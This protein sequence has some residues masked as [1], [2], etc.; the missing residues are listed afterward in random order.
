MQKSHHVIHES[1]G[2]YSLRRRR[3]GTMNGILGGSVMIVVGLFIMFGF[4]EMSAIILVLV[5][6]AI[7][8][9]SSHSFKR[10]EREWERRQSAP[11]SR[12]SYG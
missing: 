2:D 4:G 7:L 5:G 3:T 10:E 8:Y 9:L 1:I 11:L 6:G 12:I